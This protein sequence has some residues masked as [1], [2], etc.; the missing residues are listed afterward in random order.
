MKR[1]L[2][3]RAVTSFGAFRQGKVYDIDIE[4]DRMMSLL[5]VGYL[6][7]TSDLEEDYDWSDVRGTPGGT[8][9]HSV[10]VVGSSEPEAVDKEASD[11]EDHP[12]PGGDPELSAPK[13]GRGRGIIV[14]TNPSGGEDS[15]A[16]R[17]S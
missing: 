16:A 13:R 9:L 17:E 15:G 1:R 5:G 2:E 11:V 12:G 3:V 4:D 7:P 6:E 10:R 14:S 8:G